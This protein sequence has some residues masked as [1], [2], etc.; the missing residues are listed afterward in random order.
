MLHLICGPSGAGKTHHLIDCIRRNIENQTPCYLLVPEQQAYISERDLP[1]LLP[2]NAGLF[3]EIVHFSGLAEDVFRKYGGLTAPSINPGI[4]SLLM[5]DTMR[6]LAPVLLQY[7]SAVGRDATLSA[8]MLRA[9]T[10]LRANGIDA[11]QLSHAVEQM[12]EDTPLKKKLSDL[13]AVD[14]LYHERI[15]ECFGSDPSDTL[16]RLSNT[17]S[18]HP[19]F[20][21]AHVYIDSFTS[22]TA[23]EYAVLKQILKQAKEV[24]VALPCDRF[25]SNLPHFESITESARR[26]AKLASELGLEVKK[27]ELFPKNTEKSPS[28]R[29]LG[30][31]LWRF[32]L[33][34]EEREKIEDREAVTLY[35]TS[36]V[37]EECDVAAL[38]ILHLVQ[39]G[40]RYGEIAVVARDAEAYRGVLDI[41]L[42]KHSIPYFFSERTDFS[43]K[44]LSRLILSALRAVA[45]RD[46]AEDIMSLVKTGLCGIDRREA[47]LFEEYCTTWHISGKRFHEPTWNMNP[48]GLTTAWSE[49]GY[50]ILRSANRVRKAVMEPLEELSSALAGSSKLKDRCAALYH[51]LCRLDISGQLSERARRELA[52]G[53]KR[54]AGET[55]R[56]YTFLTDS[57]TLLCRIMPDTEMTVDEFYTALRL[58]FSATDLGSVPPVN[59]CVIIGSA[60]TLRLE[61]VRAMF[62]LGLCEGEFPR[63]ASDDGLL[64]EA[65]KAALEEYELRIDSRESKR[66]SEELFYVY[67]A[68]TKPCDAL[69]L[70]T[71]K[72]QTDGSSRTPSLAFTRACFLLDRKP[73]S[74]DLTRLRVLD[75]ESSPERIER[76]CLSP[77]PVGTQLRLSQSKIRTFLLCP[78]SYYSTYRLHLREQKDAALSYA[79]DGTFLHYVFEHFL[80]ECLTEDGTLTLPSEQALKDRA[81]R[82]ILEYLSAVYPFPPEDMDNRLFHTF[83]RLRKLCLRM[84]VD[85]VEELRTSLFVP[86]RFE[87]VIGMP[88]ETGLP[89]VTLALSNGSTVHLS[90]KVDR[91]DLYQKGEDIYVRVIDYKAG[92]HDF[93]IQQVRS[94][95][96]IQLILYLF[97]ALSSSEQYRIGGAEFVYPQK[98]DIVHSGLISDANDIPEH[99]DGTQDKK[100]SQKRL[101]KTE[102]EIVSLIGDMNDAVASVAS[103]ILD[104]EVQKTPSV[105]A[106]RY[107]AVRN[108]CDKAISEQ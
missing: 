90:G 6:T 68:V 30:R 100:F 89:P 106:C 72:A 66:A 11:E 29:I 56:L 82:I 95:L 53:Q 61:N 64:T 31:D 17:L 60:S 97:A 47:S 59:D 24:T 12:T 15:L 85:I 46:M 107:C 81:D 92:R 23:H 75:S 63:A 38:H 4:R 70:S 42:Q 21:G 58:L 34:R 103:R 55:L 32:E 33:R 67:R 14:A 5:W 74:P 45:R 40:M 10:E 96:D 71:V 88:G 18:K 49:R 50:E 102:E 28:L 104:G 3:F 65:D 86:Y 108:S 76:L 13:A 80:K 98:A 20:Q 105:D 22:F 62:L 78:Y 91:I 51:Y 73:I 43:S 52:G 93:S 79:D 8:R 7:G 25:S 99:M 57:L 44:P 9:I 54:E 94:G 101:K 83:S 41:A 77:L 48:D 36:N 37:Y 87:Q 1:L 69:I 84:L 26:L 16:L 27:T 39:N 2:K 35:S 19:Y